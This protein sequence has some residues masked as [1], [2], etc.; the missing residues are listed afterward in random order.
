[1]HNSLHSVK[2]PIL[3]AGLFLAFLC[4][5]GLP[6][7]EEIPVQA[8][9]DPVDDAHSMAICVHSPLVISSAPLLAYLHFI[10]PIDIDVR[11]VP[12]PGY[13]LPFYRPPRPTA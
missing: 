1:M 13:T 11:G 12:T 9:S 2:I 4:Q 5:V 7:A 6:L 8:N 3:F 10:T